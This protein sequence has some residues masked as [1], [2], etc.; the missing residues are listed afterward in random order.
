[1][2][3]SRTLRLDGLDRDEMA[4]LIGGIL[5]HRPD[6]ALVDAV[7][8]RSQGNPFFAEELTAAR[9]DA[10]AVG[11]A[12]GRDHDPGRGPVRRGPAAA[13]RWSRSAGRHRRS[14][15]AGRASAVLDADSLDARAGRGRRR[16]DPG[17]R[18]RAGRATGSATRCSARRCTPRCCP[19]ERRRLHRR[20][21]EALT[22]DASPRPDGPG[23]R[24]AELAAHWWAAGEWAEASTRRWRPPRPPSPCGPSRRRSPIS[25]A[26]CAALD[27]LPAELGIRRRPPPAPGDGRRRRP[28]WPAPASGRSS[29]PERRSTGRRRVAR[30]PSSVARFYA[31]LGRNAWAIG[32]SDGAFDAYRRAAALVPADP[33]RSSWPGS[34]PRRPAGSCSCRASARRSARCDEALAVATAVGA[35]AE[36]GH[37][38]YTLGCCRASLGYFDEGI[39][40]GARGA[41]HRRGAGRPRRPRTG[42]TGT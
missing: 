34:W 15:A 16:A 4:E 41:G 12:A 22:A 33:P 31:L 36:E 27:R 20:V 9:H 42:P 8:A 30:T 10:V 38:L 3:G 21:A 18:R 35:R 6:W 28:T 24:A 14:P 5:G 40:A 17:R 11:R 23:H 19:G 29:W 13:P 7:W 26:R 2:P 32:D 39:D 1:M 25:S 37:V